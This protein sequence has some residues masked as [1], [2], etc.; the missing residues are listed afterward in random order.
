MAGTFTV[1]GNVDH[2]EELPAAGVVHGGEDERSAV[3]IQVQGVGTCL[4]GCSGAHL[5]VSSFGHDDPEAGRC[6]DHGQEVVLEGEA[7]ASAG[8]WH[9]LH[10]EA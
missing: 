5:E 4:P 7:E 10:R 3:G 8:K 2:E 6:L 1:L 9:A